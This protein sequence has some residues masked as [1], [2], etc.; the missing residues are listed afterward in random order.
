LLVCRRTTNNRS[1][2]L[3]F[4]GCMTIF[5]GFEWLHNDPF[6]LVSCGKDGMLIFHR[7]ESS[8]HPVDNVCPVTVRI[9]P[10]GHMIHAFNSKLVGND[11]I[12]VKSYG[13]CRICVS[14]LMAFNLAVLYV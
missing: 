3:H 7:Y 13:N 1:K 6:H 4:S 8:D 9:C 12:V 5:A 14:Y 2:L 10:A 11:D